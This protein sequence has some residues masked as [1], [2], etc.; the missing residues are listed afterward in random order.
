MR[1]GLICVVLLVNTF[2]YGQLGGRDTYQ[3]LNLMSS[4]RQAALGGKIIT[5]F[6]GDPDAALYNP[7]AI[8]PKMDNQLSVNYANYLADVNYGTASYAYLWD[9]HV[10]VFHASV[11]YIN[12]GAFEGRDEQGNST[13]SFSGGEAA[14]SLGYAY[15]IPWTK[16]YVGGHFKLINS[17]LDQ[18]NSFGIAADL[19]VLY[20]YE[21]LDLTAALVIRNLGTQI[22]YFDSLREN[23]PLE[24]NAGISQLVPHVPIRWHVTLENLQLWNIAFENDA[25]AITDLEGNTTPEDLNF[26][27][28]IFRHAI[29]G[30]ELFPEAGFN[31]RLGYN[32]RRSA[33]LRIAELRTFSGLSAGFG[34]KINNWRFNY[35]YARYNAVGATSMFGLQIGFGE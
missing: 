18:Y 24:I 3:F 19:G 2:C 28:N 21:K 33:E 7:A 15:N 14:L 23:L 12:Y 34:L 22:T 31:I 25:R 6:D 8:N 17:R 35:A 32:F 10:Q 29:V 1:S 20:N 26:I 9:R 13:S 30:V 16:I 27:D 11:T 5:N 4:P